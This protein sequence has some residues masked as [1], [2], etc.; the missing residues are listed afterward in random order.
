MPKQPT[1]LV[2]GKPTRPVQYVHDLMGQLGGDYAIELARRVM[3]AR[4]EWRSALGVPQ[5]F[6]IPEK[7]LPATEEERLAELAEVRAKLD[8]V[9]AARLAS[10]PGPE[11]E[12]L[13]HHLLA[14]RHRW[15][16]LKYNK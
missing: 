16:A 14:L 6:E 12:S 7:P 11:C 4:G 1:P 2:R 15:V 5:G 3:A 9:T 13:G 10:P 8:Q